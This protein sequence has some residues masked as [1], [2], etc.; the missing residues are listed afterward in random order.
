[1]C[2]SYSCPNLKPT[3]W[4]AAN[5]DAELDEAARAFVQHP[6]GVRLDANGGIVISKIYDWFS[7]DFGRDEAAILQHIA[8]YAIGEVATAL[9]GATSV[10]DYEYDWTLNSPE[11]VAELESAGES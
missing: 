3:P 8:P 6:R 4:V 1:N 2:A 11:K 7:R 10:A 5:L 9:E